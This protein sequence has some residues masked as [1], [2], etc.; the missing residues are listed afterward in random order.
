MPAAAKVMPEVQRITDLVDGREY[1]RVVIARVLGLKGPD[2]RRLENQ[3]KLV[4]CRHGSK[5]VPHAWKAGVMVE[6]GGTVR[7]SAIVVKRYYVEYGGQLVEPMEPERR[8]FGRRLR[9]SRPRPK[10]AHAD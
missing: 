9:N 6:L 3:R 7:Y 8:G 10:D 2:L 1:P 4:P 5:M